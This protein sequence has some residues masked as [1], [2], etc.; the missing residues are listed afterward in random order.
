MNDEQPAETIRRAAKL[1]IERADALPPVPWHAEGRDITA[2]QDYEGDEP[3][4]NSAF[5]V[6]VCRR[7]DESQHIAAMHNT[8]R[9]LARWLEREAALIDALAF[10]ESD[11]A[12][13]KYP[14]AVALA[15]LRE[16]P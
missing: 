13:V 14:L 6:A 8:T 1:M 5:N 10:P 12:M 3:D 16:K 4:W 2:T 7:Q 11:P 15:Y 9:D